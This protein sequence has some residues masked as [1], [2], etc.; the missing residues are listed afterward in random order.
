MAFALCTAQEESRI[1]KR[2]SRFLSDKSGR[3]CEMWERF[4]AYTSREKKAVL[5]GRGQALPGRIGRC[6][7]FLEARREAGRKVITNRPSYPGGEQSPWKD[8]MS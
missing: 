1:E 7:G 4:I 2:V 8:R 5:P 3:D 6:G